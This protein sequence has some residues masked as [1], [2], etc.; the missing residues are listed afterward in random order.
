[1]VAR[2]KIITKEVIKNAAEK[3][4]YF[5]FA[6]QVYPYLKEVEQS[7]YYQKLYDK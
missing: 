3:Q 2:E 6:A 5:Q 1:L 7:T 4:K